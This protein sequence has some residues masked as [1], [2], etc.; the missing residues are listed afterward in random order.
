[1]AL[2]AVKKERT[3]EEAIAKKK[4]YKGWMVTFIQD[5]QIFIQSNK[6]SKRKFTSR[7][8]KL[9]HAQIECINQARDYI[10]E[11][12]RQRTQDLYESQLLFTWLVICARDESLFFVDELSQEDKQQLD[13]FMNAANKLASALE[14]GLSKPE[15]AEVEA[16]TEYIVEYVRN[17]MKAAKEALFSGKG[18]DFAVL[19][20]Q[21]T[22]GNYEIKER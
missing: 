20:E 14:I 4:S 17:T 19:T 11:K 21:F 7:I 16:S 12:Y 3:I 6:Y 2:K 10:D 22:K 1:M 5:R 15:N 8:E 9:E 13:R 18:D